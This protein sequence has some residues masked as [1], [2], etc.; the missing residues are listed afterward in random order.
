MNNRPRSIT[1]IS[2]FFVAFGSLALIVSL[3]SIANTDAA[4]RL[5]DLKT[6]WMVYAL[7]LLALL[8]GVFMLYGCNWARWLLV[9][10]LGLHIIISILH[11]PVELVVHS[12][13]FV[14]IVYFLFRAPASA[15]F[16]GSNGT[17]TFG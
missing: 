15:Y 16:R 2:W 3:L 8:S 9:V 6:H 11:T 10:W 14:V 12:L 5:D 17:K 4:H 1:I 7:R 13:L